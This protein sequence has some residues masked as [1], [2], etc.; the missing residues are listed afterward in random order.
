[1]A[2]VTVL[3]SLAPTIYPNPISEEWFIDFTKSEKQESRLI[4][5]FDLTGRKCFEQMV[6]GEPLIKLQRHD[7]SGG[8]YLLRISSTQGNLVIRKISFL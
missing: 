3:N 6:V 1:V 5:V 4:E 2:A 8:I 7:L